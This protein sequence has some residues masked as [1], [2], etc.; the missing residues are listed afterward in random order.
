MADFKLDPMEMLLRLTGDLSGVRG[1]V[2]SLEDQDL[3][4]ALE[5]LDE[6][7]GSL[8][9]T[10]AAV[11]VAIQQMQAEPEEEEPEKEVEN[12]PGTAPN[13]TDDLDQ[14]QARALWDWLT[15]WCQ[16]KLWPIFAQPVW[17]PCWYRHT[18]LR[19]ELTSL[20][21]NWYWSYDKKAP[22]TRSAEWL[23]RWW[24][25]VERILKEELNDCGLPRDGLQRPKHP[26]PVPVQATADNP[27]PAPP[28]FTVNDFADPAFFEWVEGNISKRRPAEA[29]SGKGD[30][31]N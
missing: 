21:A 4:V 1:R 17:K 13:W 14:E 8:R 10:L 7:V 24:P 5:R 19:I 12:W 11:T 27:T 15:E 16:N 3:A 26:V 29:K 20:C 23:A 31:G 9:E 18:K 22:P 28:A 30:P 25:H 2:Q 6:N